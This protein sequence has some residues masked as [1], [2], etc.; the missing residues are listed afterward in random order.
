[1]NSDSQKLFTTAEN[2]KLLK[3]KLGE[4]KTLP[5]EKETR[6]FLEFLD[7]I[8][9]IWKAKNPEPD[10]KSLEKKANARREFVLKFGF[11]ID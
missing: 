3:E 4:Y 1:M 9:R 10:F 8:Y 2:F 5:S 7:E 11:R 6:D